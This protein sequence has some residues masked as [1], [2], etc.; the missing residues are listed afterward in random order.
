MMANQTVQKE[1]TR[2]TPQRSKPVVR[3]TDGE[4]KHMGIHRKHIKPQNKGNIFA[5]LFILNLSEIAQV[6]SDHMNIPS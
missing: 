5:F 3:P 1:P 2:P 6:R 4:E